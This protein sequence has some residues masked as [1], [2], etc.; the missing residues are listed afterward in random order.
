MNM[1]KSQ[2][3]KTVLGA[4]ILLATAL[5]SASA[6]AATVS[7]GSL[8]L[9]INRDALAAG[10]QLDNTPAPSIY[11]EEFWDATASTYTFPQL[12]DGNTPVDLTD[13]AAN[14]ISADGLQF[15]VNNAVIPANPL[16]RHNRAT[17]FNFEPGNLTGSATGAI[18]LNGVLRFRLDVNPPSNRMLLGDMTL[19]YH[20]QLEN[21]T[22]GRSGWL[23]VNHSGFD[24]DA[25]EL[26]DVVTQ[27]TGNSLSLNGNLGFGW[28]FDHVGSGNARLA[29]TR[30]GNFSFQT[31]VVPVPAA[32]WLFLSGAVG[33]GLAGN[34]KRSVNS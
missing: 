2:L 4:N 31:T 14:E 12:R 24:A 1:K 26:F 29:E 9:N 33:L 7:G 17:T 23:L 5:L 22:P 32:A 3:A 18:G 34:R 6:R 30:I 8:T 10:T 11:L 28:G 27:L 20:P 16:G 13:Y 15:A 19:E 21:T 25:F